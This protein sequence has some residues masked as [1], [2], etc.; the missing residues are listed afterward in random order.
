VR[1][2]GPLP[3]GDFLRRLGIEARAERLKSTATPEEAAP[4]DAA[5][6]RLSGT[7]PGQMGALFKALAVCHPA[8][9]ALPGFD[10]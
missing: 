1:P 8:L 4:V 10:N 5:L 3:Q 2:L 6:V 7:G 9:P